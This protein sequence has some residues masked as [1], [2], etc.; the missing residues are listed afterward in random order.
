MYIRREDGPLVF[1]GIVPWAQ[2]R[3]WAQPSSRAHC[4]KPSRAKVAGYLETFTPRNLE[5]YQRLGF[6][7]VANHIEPTTRKE[8]VIMRKDIWTTLSTEATA[9]SAQSSRPLG[10]AVAA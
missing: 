7:P 10:G 2:G 9:F 1:V 6:R 8:Y 5:F 3:G 4:W